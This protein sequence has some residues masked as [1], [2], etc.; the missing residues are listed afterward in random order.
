MQS[1]E[2]PVVSSSFV[3]SFVFLSEATL[4]AGGRMPPPSPILQHLKDSEARESGERE[5][6]L[7]GWVGS[8][9]MDGTEAG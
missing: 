5:S 2:K 3:A 9:W 8:A 4:A 6:G 7:G 1:H